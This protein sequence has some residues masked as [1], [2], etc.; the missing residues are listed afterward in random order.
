MHSGDQN[1]IN[2]FRGRENCFEVLKRPAG[3]FGG[4]YKYQRESKTRR[5]ANKQQIVDRKIFK[6]FLKGQLQ[7]PSNEKRSRECVS[8]QKECVSCMRECESVCNALAIGGYKRLENPLS[9]MQLG[10]NEIR[11]SLNLLKLQNF[12]H[13]ILY[14]NIVH[15]A[16]SSNLTSTLGQSS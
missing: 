8:C 13:F 5:F 2:V 6:T 3:R 7:T 12:I 10:R 4:L 9:E 14:Y 16:I 11:K 1:K 15:K